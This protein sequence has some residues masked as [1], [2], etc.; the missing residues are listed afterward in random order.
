MST[1]PKSNHNA[2]EALVWQL[3]AGIDECIGENPVDRFS[4]NT[5][6][7]PSAG[8]SSSKKR[9]IKTKVD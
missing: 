5:E 3:E 1:L 4:V 7:Q 6:K 2:R 9:E 8:S